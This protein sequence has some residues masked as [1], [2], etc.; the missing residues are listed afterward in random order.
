VIV[1][2]PPPWVLIEAPGRRII[3]AKS[4]RAPANAEARAIMISCCYTP[5][6]IRK[7]SPS[8]SSDELSTTAKQNA[9]PFLYFGGLAPTLN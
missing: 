7:V 2:V 9:A 6:V 1:N 3:T 4:L 8:G 5:D